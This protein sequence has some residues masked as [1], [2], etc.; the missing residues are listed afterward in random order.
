MVESD[1]LSSSDV[2]ARLFKSTLTL[3]KLKDAAIGGRLLKPSDDPIGVV[4]RSMIW[5][6]C[7]ALPPER[8]SLIRLRRKLL[9]CENEPLK[10]PSQDIPSLSLKF[11]L[12]SRKIYV[13][14]LLDKMRAPDGS[15]HEGLVIPGVESLP[16]PN[17]TPVK[18]L[19]K[20]NPLSLDTEVRQLEMVSHTN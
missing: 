18:N 14:A 8:H 7:R 3:S 1:V 13:D 11:W 2:Y 5:K 17:Q 9:L 12:D 16:K 10:P 15:Y 6:V 20:N 19:D 4:G